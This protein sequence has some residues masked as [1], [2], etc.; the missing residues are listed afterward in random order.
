MKRP[1]LVLAALAAIAAGAAARA[2]PVSV[3]AVL[4]PQE[5]I[6]F[7]FAGSAK[8]FVL[9]VRREGQAEG[10]G[11]LAGADVTEIGWHDIRPP[12]D[13]EPQGYLQF[14]AANGDVAVLRWSVRAVFVS[15]SDGPQI[16]ANG[17]WE[18]VDGTGAFADMAGVGSLVIEPAEGEA[19]RF[20]LEG[21][22]GKA[23]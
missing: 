15:G 4:S 22:I 12:V 18:L 3:T 9:A 13:G 17:A 10:S 20:V 14:T 7:D 16:H 21:E 1:T 19:R 11:V 2:E 23:P 8:H 6:K 5:Q